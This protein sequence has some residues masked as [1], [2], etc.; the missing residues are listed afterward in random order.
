MTTMVVAESNGI[1]AK[2]ESVSGVLSDH[3]LA[4]KGHDGSAVST[5]YVRERR[6]AN[7]KRL[8]DLRGQMLGAQV[9]LAN[10]HLTGSRKGL[11]VVAKLRT[12]IDLA[13]DADGALALAEVLAELRDIEVQQKQLYTERAARVKDVDTLDQKHKLECRPGFSIE[14]GEMLKRLEG[15]IH[16]A[17]TLVFDVDQRIQKS[18]QR[19][20]DLEQRV[21]DLAPGLGQG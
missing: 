5:E 19:Y 9:D 2:S 4:K 21:R 15:Q 20:R 18:V 6:Q 12:E 13:V 10:A 8:A 14:R 11:D 7:K 16:G 17:R 1:H 3:Q